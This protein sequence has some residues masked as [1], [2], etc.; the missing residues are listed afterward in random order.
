MEIINYGNRHSGLR[1]QKR[2]YER[3][4]MEVYDRTETG[5]STDKSG[6]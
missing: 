4:I 5:I 6:I 1:V 2:N 3:K